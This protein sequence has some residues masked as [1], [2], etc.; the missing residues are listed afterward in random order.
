[1]GWALVEPGRA[2]RKAALGARGRGSV[3]I[4]LGTT[5]WL[6]VA[7]L[8]EG[9][10]TPAGLGLA[11]VL[12]IGFSLGAVYWTLVAVRGRDVRTDRETSSVRTT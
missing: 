7:G 4:V 12:A 9:F 5:P 8:V 3:Q 11:A 6:V 1:M 2:T 10:L